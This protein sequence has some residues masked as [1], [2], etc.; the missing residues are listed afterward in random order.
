[1]RF[2]RRGAAVGAGVA[3]FAEPSAAGQVRF[4]PDGALEWRRRDGAG[5]QETAGDDKVL[6]AELSLRS[7]ELSSRRRQLSPGRR[8]LLDKW[9]GS[10]EAEPVGADRTTG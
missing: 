10:K 2:Q 8:A 9:V 3:P 1:L 7:S 4:R 6:R 5:A